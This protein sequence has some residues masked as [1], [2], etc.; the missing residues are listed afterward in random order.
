MI[1]LYCRR[2]KGVMLRKCDAEL[3]D[4]IPL[5]RYTFT[6]FRLAQ[7]GVGVMFTWAQ[8]QGEGRVGGDA[9]RSGSQGKEKDE[10][11]KDKP[12]PLLCYG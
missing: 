5:K 8:G 2:V 3:M 11:G 4:Q 12:L 1:T 9:V 6:G 7:S 10:Q